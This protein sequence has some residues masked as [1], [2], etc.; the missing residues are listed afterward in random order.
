PSVAGCWGV[1]ECSR[2]RWHLCASRGYQM[3]RSV[4]TVRHDRLAVALEGG[5]VIE[6]GDA[7]S[8]EDYKL[9]EILHDGQD[10]PGA[11][12]VDIAYSADASMVAM[13]TEDKRVRVWRTGRGA[14]RTTSGDDMGEEPAE[15]E[16]AGALLGEREIP[17]KPTSI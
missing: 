3:L 2:R 5:H 17:K 14:G 15:L 10:K 8:G 7:K 9:L 1:G 12:G 16:P 11:N 6:V 4:F 13:A